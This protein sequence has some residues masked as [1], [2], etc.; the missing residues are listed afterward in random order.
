MS[1]VTKASDHLTEAEIKN[2]M[3]QAKSFWLIR[4]WM[5]IYHAKVSPGPAAEIAQRL[6]VS[7]HTVH[8]LISRYN[9]H[10]PQAVEPPGK[11]Q[12]QRAYLSL[13]QEEQ[14][15][16]QLTQQAGDGRLTTAPEIQRKLEEHLSHSVHQSTVYRLLSRHNWKKKHP[17]PRH[18]DADPQKQEAFKKT[19]E[20]LSIRP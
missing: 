11:A 16:N 19:S 14:L 10:G 9:R 3:K 12:R 8:Q 13:E 18:V 7:V 17:R 6:G 4:R 2:R 15:L 1:K 5:I 20:I